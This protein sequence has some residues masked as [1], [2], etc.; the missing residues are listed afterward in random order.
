M[1]IITDDDLPHTLTG[2][3]GSDTIFGNGGNDTLFGLGGNDSLDGGTGDDSMVGGLG[4][5]IYVVDAAGD[6]VVENAGEGTDLVQASISYTLGSNLENLTL[7][8]TANINATG[9]SLANVL[10]GNTGNNSLSGGDGNDTLNAGG[11]NDTVSG[12]NGTDV[13]VL[14]YSAIGAVDAVDAGTFYQLGKYDVNGNLFAY[15]YVYYD[16]IERV[17]LSGGSLGDAFYN[18]QAGDVFNGNAGTDKLTNLDLSDQTAAANLTINSAGVANTLPGGGSL[19]SVEKIAG[20]VTLGS[21]NDV[22]TF[23][24]QTVDSGTVTIT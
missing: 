2:G 10:I 3:A 11:G 17:S 21:G 5:D 14:D 22:V 7:T 18:Y 23:G 20:T 15:D 1:P 6:I 13:L 8:G 4:N 19:T 12:G 16:S 9:N 24:N